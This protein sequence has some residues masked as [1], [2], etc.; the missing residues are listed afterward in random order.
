MPDSANNE[1]RNMFLQEIRALRDEI[2]DLRDEIGELRS[3]FY[4]FKEDVIRESSE[5]QGQNKITTSAIA[6][7]VSA[8]VQFLP[9][10]FKK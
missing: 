1:W 6:L 7:G 2:K 9:A 3:A 5:R 8:A 10:L 4:E